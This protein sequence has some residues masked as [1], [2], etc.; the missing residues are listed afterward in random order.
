M[1]LMI[2]L[3]TPGQATKLSGETMIDQ[4]AATEYVI[5][6]L[7]RGRDRKDVIFAVCQQWNCSWS[8]AEN[9]VALIEGVNRS[10]IASRQLPLLLILGVGT[11]IAGAALLG[12]ALFRIANNASIA[13]SRSILAALITGFGMLAGGAWGTWKA[14]APLLG[15]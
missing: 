5:N 4:K 10:A 14:I 2:V 12:Y 11:M 15:K 8:E 7:G 6:E 3:S 13:S 9:F 1:D